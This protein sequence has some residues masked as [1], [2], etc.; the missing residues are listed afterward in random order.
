MSSRRKRTPYGV[1]YSKPIALRLMPAEREQVELLSR[2]CG[3]TKAAFAR[4][5]YL[6]GLPLIIDSKKADGTSLTLP[7]FCTGE[8]LASDFSS[9]HTANA[10]AVSSSGTGCIS[11]TASFY[12]KP[13]GQS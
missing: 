4:E 7:A 9:S 2:R 6:A 8:S 11:G 10:T 12:S 3:K 1:D 13:A 5:A